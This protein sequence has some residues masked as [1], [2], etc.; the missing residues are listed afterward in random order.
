[1][2]AKITVT[3]SIPVLTTTVFLTKESALSVKRAAAG[4]NL[5]ATLYSEK[6]SPEGQ[7]FLTFS[8]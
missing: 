7:D 1:M 4:T 6:S 5:T 8:S 3:H 2:N